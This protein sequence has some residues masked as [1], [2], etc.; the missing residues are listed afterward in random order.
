M[1]DETYNALT[2]MGSI[3]RNPH[4]VIETAGGN[5]Y[6]AF[7][8]GGRELVEALAW[9]DSVPVGD[10]D[11]WMLKN[12]DVVVRVHVKTAFPNFPAGTVI[13]KPIGEWSPELLKEAREWQFGYEHLCRKSESGKHEADPASLAVAQGATGIIDMNCLHC[14]RSGSVAVQLQEVN[15]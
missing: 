15:W 4:L 8:L 2:R 12:Q 14:G 3:V 11:E 6:G 5:K 13:S 7:S 10:F 9:Q 1:S